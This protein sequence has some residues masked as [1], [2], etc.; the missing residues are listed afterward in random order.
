[1][2]ISDYIEFSSSN[3]WKMKLRTLL[4]TLGVVVGIGALVSMISF[5]RGM[6]KNVTD[7]F[8]DLELFNSITVFSESPENQARGKG[9]RKK[10]EETGEREIETHALLGDEAIAVI[11]KLKGVKAVFP[12]IRFPA[13]VRF[14]DREEFR[15][16]QVIPARVATSKLMKLRFGRPYLSDDEDSVIVSDSLL[17][18]LKV[19]DISSVLGQKIEISSLT[20]DLKSF[21]PFDIPKILRGE[22]LPFS[23]ESYEFTVVGITERM[24]FGGQSPLRSSVFISPGAAGGIKKLP[25]TYVLD[26]FRLQEGKRG[27]SVVNVRLSSPKFV[28]SVKASIGEMGFRT[29]A[30]IDELEEIKTGFLIIDMILF[31]VGMI[32]L[33]V[34]SLGIINTMVMSILERYSE[35]GIMKAVG[36]SNRDIKKIFFFESSSIGL[37]GGVLGLGLG[38]LVSR[39]INQIVNFFLAKQGVPYIDYFSFP[40]WLCLGAVVFAVLVSLVSGIYPAMRAARVDPVVALRHD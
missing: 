2:R 19:E 26:L 29:F 28:D 21:N 25:F 17:R 35:I 7:T 9:E 24:G 34:A 23:R 6:Q 3:L 40:W 12:E 11:E 27:Y 14:N 39:I 18:R 33:F 15:L 10:T 30:L 22:K 1:M 38:W 5:G 16:I 4:T 31:A 8:R 32:A 36:A 37:M 13:M 20:F